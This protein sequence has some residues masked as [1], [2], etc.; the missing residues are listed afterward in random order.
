MVLW[1]QGNISVA[2]N[3][4]SR[5]QRLQLA[6]TRVRRFDQSVASERLSGALFKDLIT[7]YRLNW[8]KELAK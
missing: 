1:Q 6:F 5:T 2:S 7:E 8:S 3:R 4:A